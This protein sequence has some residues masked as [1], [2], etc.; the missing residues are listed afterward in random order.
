ME[1]N[2]FRI[3][4]TNGDTPEDNA[5]FG[6]SNT[7]SKGIVGSEISYNYLENCVTGIWIH[8]DT[9]NF[10]HNFMIKNNRIGGAKCRMGADLYCQATDVLVSRNIM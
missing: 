7:A 1:I 3:D 4:C 5:P 6:F 9:Y 2:G 8:A 10:G